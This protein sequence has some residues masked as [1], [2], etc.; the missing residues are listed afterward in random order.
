MKWNLILTL[1]WEKGAETEQAQPT[2]DTNSSSS[3]KK[4]TRA[5]F[6]F[7][8]VVSLPIVMVVNI[9]IDPSRKNLTNK[10]KMLCN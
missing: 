1:L 9:K 4:G 5:G 7:K 8:V 3:M 10:N 6:V 2:L